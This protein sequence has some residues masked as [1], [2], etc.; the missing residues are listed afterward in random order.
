MQKAHLC[1][2]ANYPVSSKAVLGQGDFGKFGPTFCHGAVFTPKQC[3]YQKKLGLWRARK[4]IP[5][6]GAK[7]AVTCA[8]PQTTW[9]HVRR[10][11]V[12]KG[13]LRKFRHTFRHAAV[14]VPKQCLYQKEARAMES[15]KIYS[16][17]LC[18]KP[19]YLCGSS[20]YPV[21]CK[22]V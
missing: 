10:C 12:E 15:P 7:S 3:L 16:F 22:A 1:G 4:C 6:I 18:K 21:S 9:S 11:K 2:S 14:F 5:L 20:N 8:V 13:N 19:I 17:H